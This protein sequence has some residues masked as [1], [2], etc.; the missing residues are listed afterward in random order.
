[1]P[2]VS[3]SPVY[4][5]T[6]G[7]LHKSEHTLYE[8][9]LNGLTQKAKKEHI[10]AHA[11]IAP[12]GIERALLKHPRH[13][14]CGHVIE[15]EAHNVH[16]L[17]AAVPSALVAFSIV[18]NSTCCAAAAAADY[19]DVPTVAVPA[20]QCTTVHTKMESGP[21]VAATPLNLILQP[22]HSW[23]ILGCRRFQGPAAFTTEQGAL[24]RSATPQRALLPPR[25][26]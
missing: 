3:V 12:S 16:G 4:L 26:R 15:R 7:D 21:Q 24:S 23:D 20:M 19:A 2:N 22:S 8:S 25:T 13:H 5:S 1:M 11:Q 18:A 17:V 9:A 14:S 10:W 6:Q